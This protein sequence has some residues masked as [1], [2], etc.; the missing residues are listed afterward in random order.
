LAAS[1]LRWRS[2]EA[3]RAADTPSIATRRSGATGSAQTTASQSNRSPVAVVTR[4]PCGATRTR[5]TGAPYRMRCPSSSAIRSAT[6]AEP[7]ATRRHS[8]TS[9]E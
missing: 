3:S 4:Q 8:H 7:S 5:V 9:Y 1:A 2:S 6:V